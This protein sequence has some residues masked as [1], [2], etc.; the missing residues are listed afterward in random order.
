[1]RK[2]ASI[3]GLFDPFTK[4]NLFECLELV[5]SQ[6]LDRLF[7]LV[8]GE[9]DVSIIHRIK[10]AKLMSQAYRKLKVV[11]KVKD[12][13]IP[14]FKSKVADNMEEAWQNLNTATKRYVVANYLYLEQLAHINLRE[15]RYKHVLS[16]AE[17]SRELAKCHGVN[18]NKAYMAGLLHDCAKELDVDLLES[19]MDNVYPGFKGVNQNLWHQYVGS[20]YL[21]R[22]FK[23]SDREVLR[24]VK[25][26]ATGEDHSKLG[27]ILFCADK[28]DPSRGYD[29]AKTIS[30]CKS[31]LVLGFEKTKQ[32][33]KE[34]LRKEGLL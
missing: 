32:E 7:I 10:I 26:H 4:E 21:S 17:L 1:M 11:T 23:I 30:L 31:N 2:V 27:M 29:S 15:K 34:F 19:Y 24:A 3:T 13:Y 28:L 8:E 20:T 5:K 14:S 9:A 22:F 33:Q 16:V 18:E 12:K 6:N 25:Y